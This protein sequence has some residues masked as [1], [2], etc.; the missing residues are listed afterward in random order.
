MTCAEAL[1]RVFDYIDRNTTSEL[2][3]E[4]ESHIA[5]CLTCYD[6]YEFEQLLKERVRSAPKLA[7]PKALE[8]QIEKLLAQKLG[9]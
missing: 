6:R 8:E 1:D 4:I 5:Q 9:S 3:A 7:A 2:T